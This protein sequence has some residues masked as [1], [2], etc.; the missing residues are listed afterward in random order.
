MSKAM[1]IADDMAGIAADLHRVP[2]EHATPLDKL[3]DKRALIGDRRI[4]IT[5]SLPAR[6]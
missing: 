1:T 2:A 4:T 3:I 5:K 6:N